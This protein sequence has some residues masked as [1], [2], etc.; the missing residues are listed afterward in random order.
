MK[1]E[2]TEQRPDYFKADWPAQYD[3]FSYLEF[4]CGVP[5]SLFMVTTTK[6]NGKPNA[7]FQAW[8]SF[9]GDGGGFFAVMQDIALNSHTYKNILRDQE[10]CIN[11]LRPEYYD[12]CMKTIAENGQDTDEIAAGGFTSEPSKSIR[13]PRI[14]EAF[15]C[16]ECKLH[17]YT[18]LSGAGIVSMVIGR[19]QHAA[20]EEGHS[21]IDNICSP[22]AFMFNVHSPKDPRTGVGD[23]SAVAILHPTG[24]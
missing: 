15:L 22:N 13:A 20:I 12:N 16:M 5:S 19:V 6:E 9:S 24:Q 7:S 11:F 2:L 3:M 23:K 4:V 21:S 10:F 14:K 8:S 18:D 17:S 1:I